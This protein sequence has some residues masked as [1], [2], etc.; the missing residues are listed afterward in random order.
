MNALEFIRTEIHVI[1]YHRYDATIV[2]RHHSKNNRDPLE[3]ISLF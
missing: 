2:L 1:C 3:L